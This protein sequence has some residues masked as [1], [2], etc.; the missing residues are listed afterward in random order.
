MLLGIQFQYREAQS[1]RVLCTTNMG[2]LLMR[3][4]ASHALRGTRNRSERSRRAEDSSDQLGDEWKS[5]QLHL[6]KSGS[7]RPSLKDAMT[8]FLY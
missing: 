5:H 6:K 2:W 3:M 7:Q 1:E 8:W 4:D